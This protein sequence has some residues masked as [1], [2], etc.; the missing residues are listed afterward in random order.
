MQEFETFAYLDM[1]KTG[2][3]F[4]SYLLT[5]C[6][7]EK[8]VYFSK[9][10]RVGE[11]YNPDKLYFITVRD[12]LDQYISLYSHGCSAGG[13][14][15]KRM[16]KRGHG[17]LYD[18]TWDGF[19]QWLKFV[20]TP[21]AAPVL[22]DEYGAEENAQIPALIGFQTFRYLE[23]AMRDPVETLRG[24]R[25]REDVVA[26]YKQKGIVNHTIR[27]ESFDR[28]FRKLLKGP[29]AHALTDVDAAVKMLEETQKLNTSDRVD[30]F[31]EDL[32]VGRKVR[33]ALKD[34]EWFMSEVLD[35]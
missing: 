7:K 22:E 28:D 17:D 10:G 8:L 33:N 29:L 35:Y 3:T 13:G 15:F 9:H 32:T 19:R 23:L 4:V 21:E 18:S 26:A 2:S 14:L 16:T 20:L 1:Q 6:T 31:Q 5:E 34:R 24:C 25:T 11:R 30:A 27:H 12:P